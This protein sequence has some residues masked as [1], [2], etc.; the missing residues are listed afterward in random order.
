MTNSCVHENKKLKKQCGLM[1][2]F[3]FYFVTILRDIGMNNGIFKITVFIRFFKR[4]WQKLSHK[5]I[6][7]NIT[8]CHN[9]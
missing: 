1:D 2:V 8:Q 6:F 5:L 9:I 3:L 7:N 4:C